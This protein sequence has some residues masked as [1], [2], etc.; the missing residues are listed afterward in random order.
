MCV[1]HLQHEGFHCRLAA[2]G[3]GMRPARAIA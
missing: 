1:S 2:S 3:A